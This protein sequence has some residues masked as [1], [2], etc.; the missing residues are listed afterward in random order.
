[1]VSSDSTALPKEAHGRHAAQRFGTVEAVALGVV[2]LSTHDGTHEQRQQLW[3]HLSV[4]VDLDHNVHAIGDGCFVG[5]HD[6]TAYA[7]VLRVV[8]HAH[9]WVAVALLDE[10]SAAIWT[11]IVHGVNGLHFGADG[12]NHAKDVLGDLVAGYGDS[13]TH[14]RY[15]SLT[16]G[17]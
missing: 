15:D 3:I 5:C 14:L 1:L 4:A 8:E 6:G 16:R 7:S 17:G 13:D 12:G 9:A 2:G 11:R 10:T